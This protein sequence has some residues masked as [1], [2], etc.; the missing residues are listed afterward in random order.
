MVAVILSGTALLLANECQASESFNI[1]EMTKQLL[2]PQK[3]D[4]PGLENT[5]R[6]DRA[7]LSGSEPQDRT[8]FESLVRLGVTRIIS[9]DGATPRHDLAKEVGIEYAHIPI[10][11]KDLQPAQIAHILNAGRSSGVVYIHCYYGHHRG[12]TAAALVML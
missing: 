8:G 6:L 12:P 7:I 10:G 2:F 3:V 11:Y 4:E 1:N 5:Y 9:V